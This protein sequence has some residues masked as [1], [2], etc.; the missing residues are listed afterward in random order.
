MDSDTTQTVAL[1]K[2]IAWADKNRQKIYVGVGAI[3]VVAA[4]LAYVS[5]NARARETAANKDLF[6]LQSLM[7]PT[8]AKTLPDPAGYLKVAAEY[9]GTG[10]GERADLLAAG[11]LF[12][13]GKYAEAQKQ[14]DQFATAYP[15]SGF[16]PQAVFG[17]ASALEAQNKTNEAITKYLEV[18]RTYSTDP[19][20]DPARLA[21]ARIYETQNK[22]EEALKLYDI[23]TKPGAMSVWS[24][25]AGGRRE[26]LLQRNPKLAAAITPTVTSSNAAPMKLP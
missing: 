1:F 15:D 22:P 8:G 17:S 18:A 9:P 25:E 3:V 14:F 7:G 5:A 16:K 24:S 10:A 23:V 4:A 6:D 26:V 19:V 11:L 2:L 12:G 21:L 13:S 20:A